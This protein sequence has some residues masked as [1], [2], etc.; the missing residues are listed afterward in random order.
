MADRRLLDS[1]SLIEYMVRRKVDGS[2]TR[3]E[4]RNEQKRNGSLFLFVVDCCVREGGRP[5][6]RLI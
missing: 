4:T 2:K 3:R 5:M 6:P 1:D